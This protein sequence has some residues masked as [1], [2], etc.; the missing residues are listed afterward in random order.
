MPNTEYL[1]IPRERVGVL[2]GKNGITKDEIEN[3]TKTD[4]NIDSETGSISVSPTEAT[5]DPLAVWKSRYIVKAIGRGFNPEI[6]LKLLSD[7][8]LLE[9]I[10]LPDYVGKSKKAI[11]R[12]KARIIGKEGRTKDII[13]D[14]TG[15]DISIYGKTVAIIGGMEQI[16]IAKEAVEMIL[17]GVRHKT[18]YAFLERKSR[19]MKIQEFHRIAKDETDIT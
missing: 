6:S 3:L 1:K 8:T 5:E 15:V 7:E 16:H 18:V 14:M 17:N 10:N 2:I 11:M 12:Q 9:I 19:D 13:I 4:I